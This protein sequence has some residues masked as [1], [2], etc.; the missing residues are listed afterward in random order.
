MNIPYNNAD[1]EL[2]S[3]GEDGQDHKL[4]KFMVIAGWRN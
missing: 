2:D 3:Q 4:E 1:L